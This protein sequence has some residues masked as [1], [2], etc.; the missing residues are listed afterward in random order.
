MYLMKLIIRF[1]TISEKDKLFLE[2]QGRKNCLRIF[3]MGNEV[4][5]QAE[6]SYNEMLNLITLSSFLNHKELVLR[7]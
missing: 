4:I 5:L 3:R 2:D 7:Q 1:D 6:G